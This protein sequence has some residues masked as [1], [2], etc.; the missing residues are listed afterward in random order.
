[1]IQVQKEEIALRQKETRE[2]MDQMFLQET[3][4]SYSMI[5][6]SEDQ[7]SV[8]TKDKAY[9][10]AGKVIEHFKNIRGRKN[11][12]YLE[13]NFTK[14]WNEH[15]EKHQNFLLISEGEAFMKELID[16]DD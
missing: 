16:A 12:K 2:H 15:D 7:H 8:I 1:M 4:E 13:E 14:T 6:E 10:A 11:L 9:I 5:K 3:I